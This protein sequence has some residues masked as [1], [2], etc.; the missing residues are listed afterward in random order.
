MAIMRRE[1][2]S[3]VVRMDQPRRR[4]PLLSHP[5]ATAVIGILLVVIMYQLLSGALFW[6]GIKFDDF[7]YGYPRTT[8]LDGYVGFGE[9]T[10]QPSHIIAINLHRQIEALVISG[11]DPSH[12]L[13]IKGPYLYDAN[14]DYAPVTVRL[15][16][17]TGDGYPDLVL[18]VEQ[19]RLI[20]VDQ[21]QLRSFRPILPAELAQANKVLGGV[22]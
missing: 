22:R 18:T 15:I 13:V 1:L 5:L 3:G 21:P 4:R 9:S 10:G 14:G 11:D 6:A 12:V 2:P 19:Q 16:D 20:F 7:R 8:S 17:V